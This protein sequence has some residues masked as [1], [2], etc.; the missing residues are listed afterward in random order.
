MDKQLAWHW[1][2]NPVQLQPGLQRCGNKTIPVPGLCL[3]IIFGF[4]LKE[5]NKGFQEFLTL[6][7][8]DIS[9]LLSPFSYPFIPPFFHPSFL[10]K[11]ATFWCKAPF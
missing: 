7:Q 2:V 3:G 9:S 5:Q 11:F 1:P 10:Y 6:T 8:G 4:C